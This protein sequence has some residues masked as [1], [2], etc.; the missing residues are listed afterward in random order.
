[1]MR[2]LIC[3]VL[4]LPAA[5]DDTF[6]VT[7]VVKLNGPIPA[8]KLNKQ[9]GSDPGCCAL[10]KELPPKEDLVVDSAG[11]V[12]WAFVY[13]KAGLQGKKF[14][15]PAE[16]VLMNQVGCIYAPH[17]AGAMVGQLVNFR[18][19]DPMLHNV[20]GIPFANKEFNFGQAQGAVNGVKFTVQEVMVKVKCE[21]HPWMASWI[22]VLDHGF[23]AVTA[24]DGKFVIPPGLKD[25]KY[26][27]EVWHEGYKSVSADVDVKGGSGAANFDLTDKKE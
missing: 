5:A 27:V 3:L 23:F 7:G 18:N 11:G 16:P 8:A 22:G 10:H 1:M 4:M 19:S 14:A 21:V 9:L 15:P 24:A 12:K 17:V 2:T 13:V 26:T 25:G 6:T 20:H